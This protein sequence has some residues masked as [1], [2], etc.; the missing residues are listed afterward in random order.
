MLR[1]W[2]MMWSDKDKYWKWSSWYN[3]AI[4]PHLSPVCA[5]RKHGW[6]KEYRSRS[7][8][9]A[10]GSTKVY[11]GWGEVHQVG[12]GNVKIVRRF[13]TLASSSYQYIGYCFVGEAY[14]VEILFLE[15]SLHQWDSSLW[16]Q[17]F[18]SQMPYSLVDIYQRF[19][20]TWCLHYE[21]RCLML[22]E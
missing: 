22:E 20:E 11:A 5:W 14:V 21:G 13:M 12:W 17:L 9:E 16:Q 18:S 10:C 15:F 1:T 3:V 8:A 6:H 4:N 19:I 7:T 2:F